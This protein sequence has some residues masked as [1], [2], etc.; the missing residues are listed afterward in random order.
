MKHGLSQCVV[1]EVQLVLNLLR[2]DGFCRLEFRLD[3]TYQLCGFSVPHVL[4][5]SL[6]HRPMRK[7]DN[8]EPDYLSNL[9]QHKTHGYCLANQKGKKEL[10]YL[11]VQMLFD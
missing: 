2:L 1:Y 10:S 7:H 3:H 8:A 4:L 6:Y 11:S 9:C 5:Y